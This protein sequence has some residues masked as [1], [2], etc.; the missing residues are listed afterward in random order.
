MKEDV[1]AQKQIISVEVFQESLDLVVSAAFSL[2]EA[3]ELNGRAHGADKILSVGFDEMFLPLFHC[4]KL[5]ESILCESLEEH[6]I[7]PSEKGL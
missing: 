3:D 6:C 4:K 2:E 5:R 7:L 1:L